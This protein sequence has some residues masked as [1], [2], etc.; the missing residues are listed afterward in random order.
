MLSSHT[1]PKSNA[2]SSYSTLKCVFR[3]RMSVSVLVHVI[4]PTVNLPNSISTPIGNPGCRNNLL[5]R[6]QKMRL[7]QIFQI[8]PKQ[9]CHPSKK[10]YD[11][12][13]IKM[14]INQ[15]INLCGSR[16]FQLHVFDLVTHISVESAEEGAG[17]TTLSSILNLD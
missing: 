5:H 12:R 3:V 13:H 16:S 15:L 8:L 1:S 9:K 7:G 4:L 2:T 10:L 14:Q 11:Q 17:E 6:S